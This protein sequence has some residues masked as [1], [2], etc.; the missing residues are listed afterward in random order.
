MRYID[1]E[2]IEKLIEKYIKKG[3]FVTELKEGCL[4]Y[5]ITMLH[6]DGLKISIIKEVYLNA[7]SS[8]HTLRMYNEMPLTYKKMLER[9]Y[10]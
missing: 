1:F 7:W 8:T 10:A 6:G 9:V 4:G 2:N 3:G 5:G